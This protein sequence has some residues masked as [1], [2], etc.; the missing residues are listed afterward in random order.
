MLAGKHLIS[1]Q[2][3]LEQKIISEATVSNQ[4]TG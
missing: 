2:A 1:L 3:I 4:Q